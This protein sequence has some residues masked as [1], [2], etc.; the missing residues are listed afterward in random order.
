MWPSFG[1]YGAKDSAAS[2]DAAEPALTAAPAAFAAD[3]ADRIAYN[4]TPPAAIPDIAATAAAPLR[5]HSHSSSSLCVP[6][7]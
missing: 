3:L 4:L 2:A 5:A 6:R 1:T 7:S